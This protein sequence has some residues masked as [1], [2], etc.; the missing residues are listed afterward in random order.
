MAASMAARTTT[1]RERLERD[2]YVL[3]PG[4]LEPERVASL[5]EAVDE[6]WRRHRDRPP[7]P[8]VPPLHLL[9]FLGEDPRFV[10]LVDLDPVLELVV[11]VL[12]PNIFVYHCHLD[13]HPP[14]PEPPRTWM[15][16]QDGG[17]VN[18]DLET[19]PRPRLSVKVAYFLTDLSEPGRGNFVVLPGSHLRNRIERPTDDDNEIPG[20]VPVLASPG[21]A[22]VFDRRLWHMRGRNASTLTRKAL[23]YAY[24]YRW[25]RPRDELRIPAEMREVLTPVRRQL[26]GEGPEAIHFWM[27]D[28]VDLPVRERVRRDA[29]H[30]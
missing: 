4:V 29:R 1:E 26:L 18:R 11:E 20:A 19:D 27:P 6:V 12:G 28:H 30:P 16:H 14:E 17:I 24:T 22:V 3:L 15:W 21:D 7:E 9:A 25:V 5:V 8:G 2:G 13:V 23:F 10:E